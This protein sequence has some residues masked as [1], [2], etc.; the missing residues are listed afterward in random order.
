MATIPRNITASAVHPT[1]S[2]TTV[3]LTPLGGDGPELAVG[4]AV[5][6]VADENRGY[7]I[8]VP[9]ADLQG[10]RHHPIRKRASTM[11]ANH[12]LVVDAGDD[13]DLRR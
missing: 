1:A 3:G 8:R 5:I 6:A 11:C 7:I 2:L 4:S 10:I 12:A 9:P 13:P